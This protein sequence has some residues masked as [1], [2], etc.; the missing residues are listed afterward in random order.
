MKV[1]PAGL[2]L[3]STPSPQPM[4]ISAQ[5]AD[6]RSQLRAA[7]PVGAWEAV[8]AEVQKLRDERSLPLLAALQIVYARLAAGWIPVGRPPSGA[9]E[10]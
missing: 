1:R 3:T 8:L 4:G 7:T 5:L 10:R 6:A 9:R 2:D